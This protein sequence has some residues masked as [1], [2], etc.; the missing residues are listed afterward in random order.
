[1]YDG[2]KI[3]LTMGRIKDENPI[4]L[5]PE[6]TVLFHT[7]HH[8]FQAQTGTIGDL[9]K[10]V[11]WYQLQNLSPALGRS[12]SKARL[13]PSRSRVNRQPT[14][15]LISGSSTV[16]FTGPNKPT[17][18]SVLMCAWIPH[19]DEYLVPEVWQY[20]LPPDERIRC[21]DLREKLWNLDLDLQMFIV[22]GSRLFLMG[23]ERPPGADEE[24]PVWNVCVEMFLGVLV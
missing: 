12:A 3:L 22:S 20:V 4:D 17:T 24:D 10:N 18:S 14:E 23:Y 7:I 9:P 2:K 13:P 8:T 19:A 16:H 1:V 11:A 21:L 5:S 15:R 6:T